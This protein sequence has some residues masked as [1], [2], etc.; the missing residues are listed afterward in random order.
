MI[1]FLPNISQEYILHIKQT[2]HIQSLVISSHYLA[3][4]ILYV[5]TLLCL[6][7]E[8]GVFVSVLKHVVSS[9]AHLQIELMKSAI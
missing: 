3:L 6:L 8:D 2:S 4:N 5:L 1:A 9:P 7:C